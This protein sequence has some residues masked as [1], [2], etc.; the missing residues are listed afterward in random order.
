M[1]IALTPHKDA[2]EAATEVAGYLEHEYQTDDLM[3]EMNI[4]PRQEEKVKRMFGWMMATGFVR[5]LENIGSFTDTFQKLT[6]VKA[7]QRRP[8]VAGATAGDKV[9]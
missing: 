8:S 5:R 2:S 6:G 7:R 4:G 3:D 1:R 9:N